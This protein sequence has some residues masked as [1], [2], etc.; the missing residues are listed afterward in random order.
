MLPPPPA[1][2]KSA[3]EQRVISAAQQQ[4]EIFALREKH[5]MQDFV[6][7]LRKYYRRKRYIYDRRQLAGKLLQESSSSFDDESEIETNGL[8]KNPYRMLTSGPTGA[9]I[10]GAL[11]L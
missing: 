2:P 8:G 6:L 1:A 3:A 10:G 9:G 11:M 4:S 7:K 5:A